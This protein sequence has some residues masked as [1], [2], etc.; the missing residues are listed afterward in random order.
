[1]V[2][3]S[4]PVGITQSFGAI[5]PYQSFEDI[6]VKSDGIVI[7]TV[8]EVEYHRFD[9]GQIYTYL[10]LTNIE[11]LDGRYDS[12]EL[13][14]EIEG[15]E[16]DGEVLDIEGSPHFEVGDHVI[17]FLLENGTQIVPFVGWTQG[18]FRIHDDI[19]TFANKIVTDY[20]GNRIFGM[21]NGTL[22]KENIH[23]DRNVF[24][25]KRSTTK[26]SVSNAVQGNVGM[27]VLGNVSSYSQSPV[28]NLDMALNGLNGTPKTSLTLEHFKGIIT[29]RLNGVKK[30]QAILNS[31]SKNTRTDKMR[32]NKQ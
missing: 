28:T 3:M 21:E 18:V 17:L 31:I 16:V 29:D 2:L 5:L 1:M 9:A 10:T 7:G 11:V 25:S 19:T 32:R 15:G 23:L 20:N 13:S 24:V 14:I 27:N 30:T 8:Y 26:K 4:M 6:I 22:I 12:P